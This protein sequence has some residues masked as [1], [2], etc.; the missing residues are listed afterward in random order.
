VAAA[1]AAIA[2]D[3]L[4]MLPTTTGADAGFNPTAALTTSM[5]VCLRFF[6]FACETKSAALAGSSAAMVVLNTPNTGLALVLSPALALT[7]T[8]RATATVKNIVFF[9]NFIFFC[10]AF[11]PFLYQKLKVVLSK[12]WFLSTAKIAFVGSLQTLSYHQ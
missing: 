7:A 9:N 3:V 12:P 10:G 2:G 6:A 5:V 8:V 4:A 11:N 1:V